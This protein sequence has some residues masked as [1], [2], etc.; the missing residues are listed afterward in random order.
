[1]LN[2]LVFAAS[3][4][5]SIPAPTPKWDGP[6]LSGLLLVVGWIFAICLVICVLGGIVSGAAIGLGKAMDNGQLQ[7][8]GLGGLVGSL[9]GVAVCG[10]IVVVLNFVFNAFGS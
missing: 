1:M 3:A 7:N 10:V 8:K 2:E 4:V 6:G 9:I 5:A